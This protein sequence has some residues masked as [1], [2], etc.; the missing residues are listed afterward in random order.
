MLDEA[1]RRDL[2]DAIGIDVY[3][4]R[5]RA[6]SAASMPSAGAPL[7]VVTCAHVDAQSV[8]G[9]KFRDALPSA[10][11]VHAARIRWLGCDELADAPAAPAYLLLGSQPARQVIAHLRATAQVEPVIA[12]ADE[13]AMSLNSAIAKRAL[14]QALKPIA[15]HLAG[16]R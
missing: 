6:E 16:I 14:W 8:A 7:L 13:P 4:L 12:V 3:I 1:R 2:L 5:A 15:R 10:L 11:M 9:A